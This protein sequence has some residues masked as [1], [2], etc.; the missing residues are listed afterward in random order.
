[1]PPRKAKR[2]RVSEPAAEGSESLH[3]ADLA[4]SMVATYGKAHSITAVPVLQRSACECVEIM[5]RVRHGTADASLMQVDA[6]TEGNEILSE[7]MSSAAGG[8]VSAATSALPEVDEHGQYPFPIGSGGTFMAICQRA[9]ADKAWLLRE[10]AAMLHAAGILLS[11]DVVELEDQFLIPQDIWLAVLDHIGSSFA[12]IVQISC[13][14]NQIFY[15]YIIYIYIYFIY[16]Y[17]K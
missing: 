4:D 6:T 17:I 1:M 15:I 14:F 7:T 8:S 12:L 11:N 3:G 9:Q 16:I 10:S 2:Q 13:F 5:Y